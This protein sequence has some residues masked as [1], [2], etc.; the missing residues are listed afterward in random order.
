MSNFIK[1]VLIFFFL[2]VLVNIGY[3]ILIQKFDY[4]F[5]KRL[6]TLKFKS[7]DYELLVLGNSLAFDGI[8]TEL[9][10]DNGFYSYNLALGGSSLKTNLIQLEEYLSICKNRPD[11]IVLGLGTYIASFESNEIHPI[12]DFTRPEKN[13]T[14]RDI[15]IIKFKWIFKELLK[16]IVSAEHRNAYLKNGQL[17]FKKAV[18]DDTPINDKQEFQIYKYESSEFINSILELCVNNNITLVMVEM[19]GYKKTRHLKCYPPKIFDKSNSNGIL[20][21]YNNIE[22][23]KIFDDENDWIGNSH[24][25]SFGAIKF[26]KHLIGDLQKIKYKRTKNCISNG[27]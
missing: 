21:D 9:L 15:P 1:K 27:M 7:P 23:C 3:L 17:R 4:N 6:E 24:L 10:S 16:R 2:V 13:H 18:K 26:T 14:I 5:K 20:L 19:S 25:N 12:V 22:F 8:D 11:Y